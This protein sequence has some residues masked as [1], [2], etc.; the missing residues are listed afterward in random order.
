M[1]AGTFPVA[2]FGS[3]LAIV[4]AVP[5]LFLAALI[6]SQR[7]TEGCSYRRPIAAAFFS[8]LW[9]WL[10]AALVEGSFLIVFVGMFIYIVTEGKS[11]G[12]ARVSVV[13]VAIAFGSEAGLAVTGW[14][15]HRSIRRLM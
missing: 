3:Y 6:F 10:V 12:D 1:T 4:V 14:L 5:I 7:T 11:A 13:P 9:L 2:V 15:I 8:E